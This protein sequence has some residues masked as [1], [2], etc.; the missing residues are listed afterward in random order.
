MESSAAVLALDHAVVVRGQ[1]LLAN[2]ACE[3]P[4]LLLE[5]KVRLYPFPGAYRH[6]GSG[7]PAHQCYPVGFVTFFEVIPV[8]VLLDGGIG[9]HVNATT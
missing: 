8:L 9:H 3:C 5:P 1:A 7:G 2:E 4:V 6:A